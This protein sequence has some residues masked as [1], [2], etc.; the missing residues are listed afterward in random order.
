MSASGPAASPVVDLGI[1]GDREVALRIGTAWKE[2]RR[3]AASNRVVQQGKLDKAPDQ[4][5]FTNTHAHIRH[6]GRDVVLMIALASLG[7]T[8][9]ELAADNSDDGATSLRIGFAAPN[10]YAQPSDISSD[11]R[12]P[13]R[14]ALNG[15]IP[16]EAEEQ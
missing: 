7:R 11:L 4:I 2:L 14:R 8:A 3:G 12:H 9:G 10:G 16:G 1:A 5:A 6:R 13:T 15:A